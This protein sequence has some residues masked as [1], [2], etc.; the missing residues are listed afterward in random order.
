MSEKKKQPVAEPEKGKSKMKTQYAA[1]GFD[2]NLEEVNDMREAMNDVTT[3]ALNGDDVGDPDIGALSQQEEENFEEEALNLEIPHILAELSED[4][5]R[6]YLREIG[7][8]KLLDSDSEFRLATLIAGN[9]LVNSLRHRPIR[10][11][12]TEVCSVYHALLTDMTTAWERLLE[13]VERL[14]A[15]PLVL[16]QMLT[17]AQ[18]LN[19]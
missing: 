19:S 12:L 17:K 11:G 10:K 14:H 18:S 3:T 2:S 8:V 16:G 7:E 4:P 5:V 6:L 15:Q 1:S 9:R 13:D